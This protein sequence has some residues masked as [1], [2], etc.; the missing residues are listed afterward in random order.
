MGGLPCQERRG[1]LL[2]RVLAGGDVFERAARR[3]AGQQRVGIDRHKA[4]MTAFVAELDL[5]TDGFA[6]AAAGVWLAH[7]FLISFL[8]DEPC[9]LL[10]CVHPVGYGS[11]DKNRACKYALFHEIT[12]R[13]CAGR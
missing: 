8:S 11:S 9:G 2:I 3:P 13:R 7:E 5:R 1:R 6:A 4:T 12:P 10:T